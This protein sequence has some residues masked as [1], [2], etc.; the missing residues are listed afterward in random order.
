MSS[1]VPVGALSSD[2]LPI[3]E[4]TSTSASLLFILHHLGG[5]ADFSDDVS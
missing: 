3:A 1:P 4:A 5:C 2:D